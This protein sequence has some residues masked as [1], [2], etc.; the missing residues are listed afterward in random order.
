MRQAAS[1]KPRVAQPP[2]SRRSTA[3]CRTLPPVPVSSHPWKG[4]KTNTIRA[5]AEARMAAVIR[6]PIP[7]A[8]CGSE[9]PG[10]RR[11]CSR[12]GNRRRPRDGGQG[13]AGHVLAG[14]LLPAPRWRVAT[15]M[16]LGRGVTCSS[17]PSIANPA[18]VIIARSSSPG[19]PS[20]VR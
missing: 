6:R 2:S 10:R 7:R 15:T 19:W 18:S 17:M 16:S 3:F 14:A 8:A 5:A 1:G 11:W 13:S 4:M 9:R 20:L 12:R